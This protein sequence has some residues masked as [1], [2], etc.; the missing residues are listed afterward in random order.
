LKK[1]ALE[2]LSKKFLDAWLCEI[3]EL[4]PEL[5]PREFTS[6]IR[7]NFNTIVHSPHAGPLLALPDPESPRKKLRAV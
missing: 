6:F 1:G 5:K 2:P 4:L 7:I 3:V